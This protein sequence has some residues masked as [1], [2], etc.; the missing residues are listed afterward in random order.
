[1][2]TF[3]CP[4]P[5]VW[6]KIHT[7]LKGAWTEMG[8]R[9]SP[10]PIPLILAGWAYSEDSDKKKRWAQTVEWARHQGLERLILELTPDMEY[11]IDEK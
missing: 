8:S 5:D 10:P 9:G 4:R 7:A 11:R 1:M 3:V 2:T 6:H